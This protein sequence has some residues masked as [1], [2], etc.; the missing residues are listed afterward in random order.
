MKV[1]LPTEPRARLPIT[2]TGQ[3]VKSGNR[4]GVS[5]FDQHGKLG[6][7]RVVTLNEGISFSYDSWESANYTWELLKEPVLVE[8]E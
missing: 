6:Y 1:T 4:V 5:F 7:F 2:K 3:L 8:N